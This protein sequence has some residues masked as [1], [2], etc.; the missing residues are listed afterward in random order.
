MDYKAPVETYT[1]RVAEVV[2]GKGSKAVKVGGE[3]VLPLHTFEGTLP[4]PPRIALQTLDS[5][6]P[7]GW[8]PWV[9]EPY[10]EA[11]RDPV[12]WARK[13]VDYGADLVAITLVSTDPAGANASADAAATVVKRVNDAISVPLVVYGTG[14]E[15][16]DVEVLTRVAEVCS[17]EALLLG[18]ALKE[19]YEPIGQAALAHGHNL[20]AQTPLDINLLKELNIKLCKFFPPDR[21]VIDPLSSPLGYGLEYSFSLMERTKQTGIIFKDN[22]TQMPIIANLAIETCKTKEAK[23]NKKQG[24]LWELMAAVSL[25]LAGANIIVVQYPDTLK[26]LKDLMAGK[27]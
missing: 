9:L 18:P 7:D 25:L 20:I 17:G 8:T 1:G 16:K 13:A 22:M 21:I 26:V 4:N 6:P 23:A 2:I 14:D 10:G 5:P 15:K 19:N 27:V 11:V 3:S 12:A 24:I